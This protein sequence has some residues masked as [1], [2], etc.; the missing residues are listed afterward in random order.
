MSIEMEP[1]ITESKLR[2][3][4]SRMLRVARF[5]G[6]TFLALKNDDKATG[7]AVAVVML[8]AL[9]YGIGFNLLLGFQSGNLVLP[10]L[11]LPVLTSMITGLFAALVWS[12]T[13]FLV[14]TKLFKGVTTFWGLLR[15]LFFS[16]TPGVLFILIS[17][18]L[19]AAYQIISAILGGWMIVGG[20]FAVKNAMGFSSERSM[21]TYLVGFWVLFAVSELFLLR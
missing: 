2:Q 20:V 18:P 12:F 8:A 19:S 21:L 5:D 9:S 4:F 10:E 15:P 7:Q 14:G 13:A 16:T 6:K 1:T 11:A 3:M 17:I